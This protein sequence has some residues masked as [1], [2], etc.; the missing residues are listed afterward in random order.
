MKTNLV[1]PKKEPLGD[2]PKLSFL[3]Q[4][5]ALNPQHFILFGLI[6]L[7]VAVIFGFHVYRFNHYAYGFDLA[8][9]QQATWNTLHGRFLEVSATDFSNTIFGTDALLILA[10]M[11]PFYALWQ[12]PLMLLLIETIVVGLGALPVYLLAR[13]R[14]GNSWA[15]LGFA[16]VYLM[17]LSVQ[18]SNLYELRERPMAMSFLLFAFYFYEE[19]RFKTFIAFAVLALCCRPEN[20]LVLIMLALYGFIKGWQRDSGW[21]FILG[22]LLLGAIWFG[23]VV[24]I[25]IPIASTGGIIALGENFPGGSPQSALFTAITNPAKGFPA[26]FPD[27]SVLTGKLL[28]I[29]CLLLPMLFL[30]LG[31]PSVLLMTLPPLALNLLSTRP[32]QWDAWRYHYQGSII[33]WLMAGTIFTVEKLAK[34]ARLK[35]YLKNKTLPALVGLVLLATISVWIFG[36]KELRLLKDEPSWQDGK[37]LLAEIPEDAPLAITNTWAAAVP[38]RQGLWFFRRRSLYSM[39]P[40]KEAQYIFAW[41]RGDESRE[42]KLIE[43][44]L[45]DPRWQKID[46]RGDYVLLK[47]G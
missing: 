40:E 22:P 20:G 33:P 35:G 14:L 38:P 4:H 15:G 8:F 5:S 41:K 1:Q 12:S 46:Q 3:T 37:A 18:N 17:L 36:P 16:L 24:Y 9:Y 26:L 47:R 23:V 11:A 27:S 13:K 45:T 42:T 32:I 2:K 44:V 30:P 31:S 21:R 43:E 34:N 39:T 29:P 10:L 7:Y 19:R 28:Y 6:L 25:I